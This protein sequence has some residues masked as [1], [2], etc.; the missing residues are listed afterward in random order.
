VTY[1]ISAVNSIYPLLAKQPPRPDDLI[2]AASIGCNTLNTL[3]ADSDFQEHVRSLL[4]KSLTEDLEGRGWK[5]GLLKEFPVFLGEVRK[6]MVAQQISPGLVDIICR[7][8]NLPDQPQ[9][10]LLEHLWILNLFSMSLY[11]FTY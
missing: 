2:T 9:P 8:G 10:L 11:Y 4:N 5:A 6:L 1:L 3:L 7:S